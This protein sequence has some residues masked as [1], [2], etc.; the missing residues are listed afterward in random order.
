MARGR[1]ALAERHSLG[2]HGSRPFEGGIGDPRWPPRTIKRI[3]RPCPAGRIIHQPPGTVDGRHEKR[4]APLSHPAKRG[5]PLRRLIEADGKAALQHGEI[6]AG[7]F[8]GP[9]EAAIGQQQRTGEVIGYVFAQQ[10]LRLAR[11]EVG[12]GDQRLDPLAHLQR[13]DLAGNLETPR[14]TGKHLGKLQLAGMEVEPVDLPRHH[15]RGQDAH[16][17]AVLLAQPLTQRSADLPARQAQFV[18]QI[19]CRMIEVREVVLPAFDGPTR[20][21]GG[22]LAFG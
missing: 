20:G 8:A 15:L 17:D 18:G 19:L 14:R 13:A 6:V 7:L 5:E 22:V 12:S 10:V 9:Q 21:G 2:Q 11:S 1:L 4:Q 3:E 16:G